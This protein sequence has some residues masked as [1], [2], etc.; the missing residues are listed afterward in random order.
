MRIPDMPTKRCLA[1]ILAALLAAPFGEAFAAPQQQAP[2]AQQT[3]GAAS[4]Q[5]QPQ[6]ADTGAGKPE[7]AANGTGQAAPAQPSPQSTGQ[8][9]QTT[10]EPQQDNSK[11]LG[12]AA[13]PYEKTEGVAASRPAGAV[14]A[15]AKQ[16]RARAILIR[17]GVLVG[18]GV[19]VGTV[20]AL[21]HGSPSHPN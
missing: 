4:T 2:G 12:T 7:E 16:R 15:P 1:C 19:A 21:S 8:S 13:A 17:V 9:A 14:I 11:P 5:E 10:V 20:V 18:A 6:A 3:T